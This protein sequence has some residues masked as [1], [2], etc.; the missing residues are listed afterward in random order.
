LISSIK[1]VDKYQAYS[2]KV[3][4]TAFFDYRYTTYMFFDVSFNYKDESNVKS[5]AID[6]YF[7]IQKRFTLCFHSEIHLE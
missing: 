7:L 5:M 4:L 2:S 1:G 6:L 3:A